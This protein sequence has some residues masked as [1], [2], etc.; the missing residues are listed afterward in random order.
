MKLDSCEIHRFDYYTFQLDDIEGMKVSKRLDCLSVVQ[1][2][3]G[4]YDIQLD[5]GEVL[6]TGE[7][8]FFI[9]PCV[10]MQNITHHLNPETGLF[11]ARYFFLDVTVGGGYHL[12]DLWDFPV[13]T[14]DNATAIL[15]RD[16]DR[17]EQSDSD[18]QRTSCM[19]S[20]LSHLLDLGTERPFCRNR[21][22]YPLLEY[23]RLHYAQRLTVAEMAALLNISESGL[24]AAF[25][26]A[27]GT[28]PIRY[29]NDYRLS[30]ARELLLH[31]DK[32]IKSVAEAVGIPDPFYFSRLFRTAYGQSP[33]TYRKTA[34]Y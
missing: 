11:R 34:Y 24:Y 9:A 13:V 30:V 32:S 23:I 19:F 17:W 15:S 12:E 4:S 28:S 7:G 26:S 8:G 1:S 5:Q 31:T 33:Q 2:H 6:N 27:M 20:F 25:K 29:L 14:D 22:L 3:T 18:G 10:V 16:I 21:E